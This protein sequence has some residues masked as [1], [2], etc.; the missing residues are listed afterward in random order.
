M[1]IILTIEHLLDKRDRFGDGVCCK[2][3]YFVL[4]ILKFVYFCEILNK[5]RFH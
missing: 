2:Y 5:L 1:K 4:I 3:S